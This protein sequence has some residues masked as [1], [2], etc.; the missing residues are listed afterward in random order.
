MVKTT[1]IKTIFFSYLCFFFFPESECCMHTTDI[2]DGQL[3]QLSHLA[4]IDSYHSYH[5]S[6]DNLFLEADGD[7]FVGYGK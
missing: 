4:V 5:T 6:S 2:S 7:D 1:T 3:P